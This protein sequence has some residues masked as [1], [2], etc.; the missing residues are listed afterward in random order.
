VISDT[1]LPKDEV[2]ERDPRVPW[3]VRDREFVL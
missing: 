1:G 2:R 3:H